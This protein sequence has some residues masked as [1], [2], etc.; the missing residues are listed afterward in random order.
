MSKP[1]VDWVFQE[2]VGSAK[3][4]EANTDWITKGQLIIS[5]MGSAGGVTDG[6]AA[7]IPVGTPLQP[8]PWLFNPTKQIADRMR[9]IA[10]LVWDTSAAGAPVW[11]VDYTLNSGV[12][13]TPAALA[14]V[15]PGAGGPNPPLVGLGGGIGPGYT[16]VDISA[17]VATSWFNLRIALQGG[18]I[19]ANTWISWVLSAYL[20]NSTDTPH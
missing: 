5:S 12:G 4:D 18:A 10:E 2:V 11:G 13:W 9:I 20:W 8:A 17:V 16:D 1:R 7:V 6:V 19:G 15:I 3:L 14:G